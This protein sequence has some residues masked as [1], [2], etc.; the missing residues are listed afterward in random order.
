MKISSFSGTVTREIM[1]Y[2]ILV[3]KKQLLNENI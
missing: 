1:S 2:G 3:L